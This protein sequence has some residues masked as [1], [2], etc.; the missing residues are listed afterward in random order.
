MNVGSTIVASAAPASAPIVVATSRNSPIRTFVYPSRTYAAAAPDE[1][2]ITDTSD[3]PIAYRRSTWNKSPSIRITN[4]ILPDTEAFV[5]LTLGDQVERLI[6]GRQDLHDQVRWFGEFAGQGGQPP[7]CV[8][9][10]VRSVYEPWRQP[11]VDLREQLTRA[12][13]SK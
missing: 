3:A 11:H 12:R 5:V 13:R 7:R 1:V 10:Q 2:A 8:V 4:P 6:R 9:N